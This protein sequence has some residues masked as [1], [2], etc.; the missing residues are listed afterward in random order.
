MVVRKPF[1]GR[2]FFGGGRFFR[3][4]QKL[5]LASDVFLIF[6]KLEFFLGVFFLRFRKLVFSTWA[7]F[8]RFSAIGVSFFAFSGFFFF[9]CVS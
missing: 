3:R 7:F 8:S 1:F 6:Q 4:F 5:A 2:F 9:V